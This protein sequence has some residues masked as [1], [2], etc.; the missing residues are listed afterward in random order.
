MIQVQ[1][2]SVR[3]GQFSLENISFVVPAGQYAVLMGKTGSG[4]TTVLE[5]I[6]GLRKVASGSIYLYEQDVTYL[7][8][9]LRG[10]GFVPQDGALF[11][12]MSVYDHLAFSLRIRNGK[13][14]RLM[15]A[16]TNW[17]KCWGSLIC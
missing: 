11:S 5:A 13:I 12:T 8:P 6:C 15:S 4:K 2:L 9:A 17:Q 14:P 16:Y 3:L 1:D 10:I 7:N